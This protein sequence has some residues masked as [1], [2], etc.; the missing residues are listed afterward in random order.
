MTPEQQAIID[1]FPI[2]DLFAALRQYILDNPVD[3]RCGK[4]REEILAWFDVHME[5]ALGFDTPMYF[6]YQAMKTRTVNRLIDANMPQG[7]VHS[8][9]LRCHEIIPMFNYD[10]A[11]L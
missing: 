6:V 8:F 3:E 2:A 7:I 10:E 4:T 9:C 1:E 11:D 5:Y